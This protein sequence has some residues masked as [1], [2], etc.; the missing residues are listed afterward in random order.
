MISRR[1]YPIVVV[2]G[3]VLALAGARPVYATTV[4]VKV[5]IHPPV[6]SNAGAAYMN[7]GWHSNC[8]T[9]TSGNG[10]DWDDEDGTPVNGTCCTT[11]KRNL[12]LTLSA[13]GL[14]WTAS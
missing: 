6:G 4:Q 2:F 11:G 10:V 1:T 7:C 9:L 13:A 5:Q 12:R 14:F 8:V 3:L